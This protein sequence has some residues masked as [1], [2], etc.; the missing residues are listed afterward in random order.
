MPITTFLETLQKGQPAAIGKDTLQ[1]TSQKIKDRVTRTPQML[2][3]ALL[4]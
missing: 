2:P 3:G 4:C 1:N